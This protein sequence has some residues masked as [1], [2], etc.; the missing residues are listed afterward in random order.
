MS[1]FPFAVTRF[2]E[3]NPRT[4]V[5]GIRYRRDERQAKDYYRV[6]QHPMPPSQPDAEE[7]T[8]DPGRSLNFLTKGDALCLRRRGDLWR[9]YVC[10]DASGPTPTA[11][12]PLCRIHSS[13]RARTGD[14]VCRR[15][16]GVDGSCST[17]APSHAS[18][19]YR[20]TCRR[21]RALTAPAR[22]TIRGEA[23]DFMA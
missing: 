23:S 21:R 9:H 15:H 1:P 4:L 7:A 22:A 11:S 14:Q 19:I 20:A 18:P 16:G 10:T 2:E 12:I 13:H 17:Q 8:G 6:R 5:L 3:C